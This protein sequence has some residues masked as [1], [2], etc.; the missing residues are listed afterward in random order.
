MTEQMKMELIRRAEM[1]QRLK[2]IQGQ[3]G[4]MWDIDPKGQARIVSP[5]RIRKLRQA[6][7]NSGMPVPKELG[8]D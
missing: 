5:D 1:L 8:E 2:E 4:D 7:R 3:Q 6:L